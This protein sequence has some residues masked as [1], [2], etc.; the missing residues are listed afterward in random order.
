M[1]PDPENPRH[2]CLYQA[3]LIASTNA[4][5]SSS[6]Y[7]LEIICKFVSL[8]HPTISNS[9]T[10]YSSS[11][12]G[13]GYICMGPPGV[14]GEFSLY[15]RTYIFLFTLAGGPDQLFKALAFWGI[16]Q[17]LVGGLMN[18]EV[19]SQFS[20]TLGKPSGTFIL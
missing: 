20:G 5:L 14:G 16:S 17:T 11:C 7:G 10:R 4:G 12:L 19:Q 6:K 3:A 18:V 9:A 13:P 1:V 15:V 8:Y 2:G